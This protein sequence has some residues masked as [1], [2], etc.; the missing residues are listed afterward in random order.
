MCAAL[1]G[2]ME[3]CSTRIL[4]LTLAAPSPSCRGGSFVFIDRERLGRDV[5]IQ[6]RVDVSGAGDLEFLEAFGHRHRVDDVLR[7]L[8]R[9]F[10]QAL[11]QFEREGHGELAHLD[12]GWL[13]DDDAGQIDVVLFAQESADV[14]GEN[15]LLF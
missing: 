6:A 13:I 7:D 3:V 8:A 11:G 14:R 12:L 2:L 15:A 9:S 4:P 1:L 5:A 10:A